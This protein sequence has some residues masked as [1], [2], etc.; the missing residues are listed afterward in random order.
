MNRFS[1]LFLCIGVCMSLAFTPHTNS[2][3]QQNLTPEQQKAMDEHRQLEIKYN[4]NRGERPPVDLNK[5]PEDA[6]KKG[7]L[8]IKLMPWADKNFDKR[9][10]HA[11]KQGYVETGISPFDAINKA[12][13]AQLYERK[14]DVLYDITGDMSVKKYQE[15]HRAWGFHLIYEIRFD[16]QHDVIAA[17]KQFA[18]LD[19]VK[20]AEPVYKIK[21]IKP[22][23]KKPL[24]FDPEKPRW[25][26]N[27]PFF[28]PHQWGLYNYGQEIGGQVGVEE[29]DVRAVDAW[30]IEKGNPDFIVAVIDDGIEYYHEDLAGN[31]WPGIGWNFVQGN[32]QINPGF[33]GTHVAG[34]VA[35]VTNN[36]IG[37][38]GLAGGSGNDDGARL[39]SCQVFDGM[40]SGGFAEAPVWAADNNAS[41][42]QNSWGYT[43]PGVYDQPV[44]DAIDYFNENGGGDGLIG[45]I[46]I[47]A[48][49]NDDDNSDWYPAYYEG[50]MAIASHDNQGHKSDFSNYGYWIEITAP[51][52]DIASTGDEGEYYYASGTSMSCPHVSGA[53]ALIVSNTEGALTAEELRDIL[54]ESVWD[55]YQYETNYPGELGYGALDASAALELAQTYL[56][57]VP[58][59][60]GFEAN[61][62]SL[63]SIA[64][65]W[66][67][68]EYDDEVLI[69]WEYESNEIGTPVNGIYYNP[70]DI[71]P[72]GG[73]ILY[74]GDATSYDHTELAMGTGYRYRIWAQAAEDRQD[75]QGEWYQE[76]DYSRGKSASAIT[77]CDVYHPP[78]VEIFDEGVIPVCWTQQNVSGSR[79]WAVNDGAASQGSYSA[80]FDGNSEG[81]ST[82]L[83]TPAFYLLGYETATLTFY[84]RRPEEGWGPWVG[85]DELHVEYWNGSEWVNLASYTTEAANFT[86]RTI[87]LENLSGEYLIAFR[88]VAS[89]DNNST[90][91][92]DD[93]NLTASGEVIYADFT[94]YPLTVAVDETVLFTDA[95]G[96]DEITSWFWEFGTGANPATATG[97][98]P[99]EVTYSSAGYKTVSL[100]VND[101]T[102]TTKNDYINVLR[103][104]ILPPRDLDYV[105]DD[106]NVE[107]SWL[108]PLIDEGW[109]TY[110]DFSLSF[111]NWIQHDLDGAPTYGIE[112]VTFPNEG[113]IGS[114]ILFN[115]SET[116]P[117]LG[118]AWEP[119]T[120]DKYAAAFSAIAGQGAPNDDWLVSPAISIKTGHELSFWHKSVTDQY[121]LERYRVGISTTE[122]DPS[123][124]T[125]I[126]EAP[127][128]QSPV[129]WT[130][131]TYDLSDYNGQEIHVTI[132]CVSDDAFVFMVD[133]FI[134][135]DESG[136]TIYSMFDEYRDVSVINQTND[137]IRE[138][139][140]SY[141]RAK[142]EGKT[143]DPDITTSD[144]RS[145]AGYKIYRNGE[146][147][148]TITGEKNLNFTDENLDSGTYYYTVTALYIDPDNESGPSNEVEVII[149][150]DTYLLTLEANPP[151]GGNPT[152]GGEYE[153]GE[154]VPIDAN[155]DE[156]Y[157]LVNWTMDGTEISTEE[158]FNYTMP[159]SN[160]TL[161]A[162]YVLL[163]DVNGDGYINVLDIVWL[164]NYILGDPHPDF[165]EAA[166]DVNQ[167]GVINIADVVAL[168]NMIMTGA[169]HSPYLVES[170]TAY[171]WNDKGDVCL[172]SDGT[173]AGLQFQI[174]ADNANELNIELQLDNMQLAYRVH[175]NII[176]GLI[177]S[178]SNTPIQKGQVK[179]MQIDNID[180]S[181]Q[182]GNVIAANINAQ[183]V[184]VEIKD[185]TSIF[186][187]DFDK[188]NIKVFPNPNTGIFTTAIDLP[189]DAKIK[190][191]L[192]DATGRKILTEPQKLLKKG[193]NEIQLSQTYNLKKGFYI[194][195]VT[196]FDIEGNRLIFSDKIKVLV[197]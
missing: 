44:L 89:S 163:G 20:Y 196:G 120:G 16:E 185:V 92:I 85:N 172:Q 142:P 152:G 194:L 108:T 39:M 157:V 116:T 95:S 75:A 49:G 105:L 156:D 22:L 8:R 19:H 83:I 65:S 129:E 33:H 165:I 127:Y 10:I 164:V 56:G 88:A 150:A 175:D 40:G 18:A 149:G 28:T 159:A 113:Y 118:G 154:S 24:P 3:Y 140:F 111:G 7:V 66:E 29:V 169:K 17:V 100:T 162:N 195:K 73:T 155:P 52:T 191:Q 4:V 180:N 76:G 145:H 182:W 45:G 86:Q 197:K 68:N 190:M 147:I 55:I 81:Q 99:H 106:N 15:R 38:A 115:P 141:Q 144:K 1:L 179:V 21:Q 131:F 82:R 158:S 80:V 58:P 146:E 126:T 110:Q 143:L 173:L 174:I 41:I 121:G 79:N 63:E 2:E 177:Y 78:F 151:Q 94:A 192:F 91:R 6:Y 112:D 167:D 184:D 128:Q 124:F 153:A 30:D 54:N 137:D 53:A 77:E 13:G 186:Y 130:E 135:S 107:L 171:I 74:A 132:H 109:E 176:K 97:Q 57:G 181:F 87:E 122:T 133:D 61:A 117:P 23:S 43:E 189:Y 35:A 161:N 14:F 178:F 50:A 138:N 34:T 123:D 32:D 62:T 183:N 11:G 96:G 193:R 72:G 102:T 59:P 125:I 70:G 31:M 27:D 47:F 67:L 134:V 71:L 51:G 114:F 101:E 69:A 98:G 168:Q 42:S 148:E 136:R 25:M 5:V 139:N 46:T 90:T 37:V 60:S 12:I 119:L 9:Y 170:Q 166:A 104:P 26:P 188:I 93:V 160:T 48:A 103:N 36:S 187:P 84:E 64:L